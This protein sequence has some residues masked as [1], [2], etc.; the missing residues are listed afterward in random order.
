MNLPKF[1]VLTKSHDLELHSPTLWTWIPCLLISLCI[2]LLLCDEE[3]KDR[4]TH[5][6]HNFFPSKIHSQSTAWHRQ[7]LSPPSLHLG[8][9]T[10][11]LSHL[12]PPSILQHPFGNRLTPVRH[13]IPNEAA[14]QVYREPHSSSRV[15]ST[16]CL[17]SQTVTLPAQGQHN[18]GKSSAKSSLTSAHTFIWLIPFIQD[19]WG[20]LKSCES[21]LWHTLLWTYQRWVS[22][23]RAQCVH[24]T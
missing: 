1:L 12:R 13:A 18:T 20:Y 17:R 19:L 3:R 2:P 10:G 7:P 21:A 22:F 16:H 11:F 15:L 23:A 9:F 4:C 6:S 24:L 14:L 5:K 8:V